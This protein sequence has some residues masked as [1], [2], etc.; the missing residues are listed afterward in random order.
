M[1]GETLSHYKITAK[2]GEGGQLESAYIHATLG[3]LDRIGIPRGRFSSS[4]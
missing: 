1:I 3:E 4:S 2:L